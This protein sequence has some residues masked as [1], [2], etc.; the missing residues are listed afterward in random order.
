MIFAIDEVNRRTP[1]ALPGVT[2]G[3]DVYDTCGD[4]S[5]AMRAAIDMSTDTSDPAGCF[6]PHGHTSSAHP[7][8]RVKISY[9]STSEVLSR[10]AKFP[11][12]L[13]TVSS[14]KHQTQGIAALVERFNWETVGVVGS[15][16]EYGK[17]GSESLLD[18]LGAMVHVCVDFKVILPGYFDLNGTRAR[19]EL[20]ELMGT[21]QN[22]TAEAVV[23]FT[24]ESNVMLV[25]EAAI[26]M[27]LSRT[28][29]ASDTWSKSSIIMELPG[30]EAIGSVFGFIFKSHVVPG[31]ADH[32]LSMGRNTSSKLNPFLEYHLSKYPPCPSDYQKPMSCSLT[33]Q[34]C[35]ETSCLAHYIEWDECFSV[36]MAVEVI[37]HALRSLM[38][39]CATQLS[40]DETQQCIHNIE[41]KGIT[42]DSVDNPT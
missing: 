34:A 38:S 18:H 17:Y 7:D 35:M 23:L 13:R 37:T 12:F 10:K 30:I 32:V 11:T 39:L 9:A 36:Y 33:A 25:I 3:Y 26:R 8:P 1:L 4:V 42:L 22:S 5:L 24:K 27:N 20:G 15:D 28:W 14:D 31:F 29:I 6:S 16:D 19:E 2:L 21:I 41:F 40:G